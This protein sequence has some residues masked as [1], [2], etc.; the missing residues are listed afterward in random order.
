MTTGA[1]PVCP[2]PS[3][4]APPP[5]LTGQNRTSG[6]SHQGRSSHRRSGSGRKSVF[7]HFRKSTSGVEVPTELQGAP[8]RSFCSNSELQTN[9][10][11]VCRILAVLAEVG[12]HS[13]A[14]GGS[15]RVRKQART[16]PLP[17]ASNVRRLGSPNESE[18]TLAV[19]L[20]LG[21]VAASKRASRVLLVESLDVALSR[22]V[23]GRQD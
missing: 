10:R 9:A 16:A 17:G 18:S 8:A 3:S 4:R 14:V 21:H 2:A 20:M 22:K 7:I 6:S 23:D 5:K 13:I 1:E 11:L 12:L 19:E 15:W